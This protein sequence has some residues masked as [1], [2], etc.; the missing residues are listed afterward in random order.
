M[1][2]QRV[3]LVGHHRGIIHAVEKVVRLI[4]RAHVREAEPPIFIFAPTAFGRTMV[5]LLLAAMP[6]A[7]GPAGFRPA[8]LL[9]FDA[10]AIKKG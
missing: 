4:V 1:S 5:R 7:D 9:R 6:F 10:D 2:G 8:I 3:L